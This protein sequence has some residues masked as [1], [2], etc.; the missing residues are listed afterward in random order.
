LILKKEPFVEARTGD[1]IAPGYGAFHQQ[2]LIDGK[3]VCVGVFDV[4]PT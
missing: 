4:L 2:Y 3:I 1:V